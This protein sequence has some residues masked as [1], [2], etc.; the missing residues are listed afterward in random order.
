MIIFAVL[1]ACICACGKKMQKRL[2]IILA[3]A[4]TLLCGCKVIDG[5]LHDDEAVARVGSEKLYL[6]ELRSVIPDGVSPED[7]IAIAEQYISTWAKDMLFLALADEHLSKTEKD[8]SKELE[9]YRKSLLR[10][11]YEQRYINERLDTVVSQK[12]VEAYYDS[13]QDLFRLDVPVMKVRFLDIMA[14]SP[15]FETLRKRIG[16]QK[17]SDLA[18]IDSLAFSSALRYVDHSEDWIDAVSIAR[19]FG[20]DYADMLSRMK[21]GYIESEE[22]RGDVK[23][24]YVCDMQRAGTIAPIEYCTERI[25]DIIIG[26]RKRELVNALEQELLESGLAQKNFEIY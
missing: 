4:M 5:L 6:S 10:Y 23:I 12:A 20:M 15:N 16:S 22:D 18:G 13:H 24:A 7:S 17:E 9:D 25:K 21:N 8:V 14:D 19:E 26:N 3:F 11:R 1:C 2:F